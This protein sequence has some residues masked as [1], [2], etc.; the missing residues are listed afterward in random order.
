[1]PSQQI[2]IQHFLLKIDFD[3]IIPKKPNAWRAFGFFIF[4]PTYPFPT[5]IPTI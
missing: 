3:D 1:M 2:L 5:D 4:K